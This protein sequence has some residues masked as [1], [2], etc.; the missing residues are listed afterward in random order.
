MSTTALIYEFPP[1]LIKDST[2]C[3]LVQMDPETKTVALFL[4]L[5][6]FV[7]LVLH[8]YSYNYSK[9]ELKFSPRCVR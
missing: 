3:A 1:P 7:F 4:F 6:L 5:L 2:P 9:N 8:L